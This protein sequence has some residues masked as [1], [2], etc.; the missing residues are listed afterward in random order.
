MAGMRRDEFQGGARHADLLRIAIQII[1]YIAFY[2]ATA[3]VVGPLLAW[4]GGY[5]AGITITGLLAAVVA[6]GLCVR[7]YE[8]RHIAAIGLLWDKASL[9]NL[10]FGCLGGTG[11]AALVLAGPLV[12]RA[13]HFVHARESEAAGVG[14][15]VFLSVLLLLGSAG[16]EML[17]RGY[18]FQ[19]LLRGLGDWTTILPVGVLFAALHAFNPHAT[20]L[21]LANTAGFGILFGYAFV[22]SRDLWLPIGL[23]FG[24]NFTLPLFGVN[25]S[26][27]TMRLTGFNME[28]SAGA[29]WSGGEYGPEASILTSA[30]LLLLFGYIWKAPVR[31]QPSALLDPPV[32]DVTCVPGQ[33]VSPSS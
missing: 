32:G 28:W 3:F 22:R 25:V 31:R 9:A 29:L 10:G 17:F 20:W 7:I 13:A 21:G 16:E 23:H 11:A 15:F 26:G 19:V 18:G 8:R 27:L 6:N 24:W 30:V 1:V 5:I 2:F 14:S 12:A 33:P 4:V